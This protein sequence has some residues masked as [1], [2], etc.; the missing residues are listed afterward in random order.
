MA[1]LVYH[2]GRNMNHLVEEGNI[3]EFAVNLLTIGGILRSRHNETQMPV[4]SS[5][6]ADGVFHLAPD[7]N[8]STVD[9]ISGLDDISDEDTAFLQRHEPYG[10]VEAQDAAY[11]A[12][13]AANSEKF[14]RT[15]AAELLGLTAVSRF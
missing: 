4:E 9:V 2:L 14:I 7:V 12:Y 8:L 10:S 3:S 6:L 15:Q 1:K 5:H 11:W 13:S